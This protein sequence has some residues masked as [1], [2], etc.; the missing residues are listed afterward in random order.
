MRLAVT[1]FSFIEYSVDV[2]FDF[3]RKNFNSE[4][5]SLD[6]NSLTV[7]MVPIIISIIFI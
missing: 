5:N 6:I 2:L 1:C 4:N 3:Y 7:P